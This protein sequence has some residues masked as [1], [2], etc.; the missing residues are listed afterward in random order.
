MRAKIYFTTFF[1]TC[2]LLLSLG[3]ACTAERNN[4]IPVTRPPSGGDMPTQ[5]PDTGSPEEPVAPEEPPTIEELENMTL[6]QLAESKQMY[7]GTYF[8]PSAFSNTS[9]RELVGKEFNLAV[10]Y[11]GITWCDIERQQDNFNF[12]SADQQVQ[13]ARSQDMAVCG[14]AIIFP[15]DLPDWL[16]FSGFNN[17]EIV[18]ALEN[19]V[20]GVVSRYKDQVD[21]WI[22]VE[23][24]TLIYHGQPDFLYD[25]LG[26]EYIDIVYRIVRDIDPEATLLYNDYG[27]HSSDG[28]TTE[29]TREIVQRLKSQDLIDGVGLEMH[30]DGD[31]PPDKQDMIATMQSY[32]IPV[33]ITEMDV[34]IK[35]FTGSMEERYEKQ[36]A[37]YRD[38]IEAFLESGVGESYSVFGMCDKYSWL[39]YLSSNVDPTLFDN[40]LN[41]KPAYFALHDALCKD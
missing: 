37:I 8:P 16:R 17:D 7:I 25:K 19:H 2:F 24:A 35:N 28:I 9:W 15:E 18:A 5:I 14:H 13:F 30:L 36:A 39:N 10:I 34:D 40:E 41:P 6:R 33:H 21:M 23:E 12:K 32:G 22:P 29:F 31:D 4:D 26:L 1:I 20:T 11:A 38:V 27:N 3:L